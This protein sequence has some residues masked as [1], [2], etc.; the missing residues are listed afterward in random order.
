MTPRR[1]A[2]A[3]WSLVGLLFTGGLVFALILPLT[4]AGCSGAGEEQGG[5]LHEDEDEDEPPGP[6]LFRDVTQAAGVQWSCRNGEEF[7]HTAI[8]EQLGGGVGL[9]DFDGDGLLDLFVVGGG[10]FEKY[11]KDLAPRPEVTTPKPPDELATL[12]KPDR[13][14]KILGHP[15]KLYRNKGNGTF[16][17]VTDKV[18]R[19]DGPWF[20]SHGC[21]VA[22]YDCDGWPDLLL[23][24]WDRVALFHNEPADPRDPAKGRR[25][26]D[27]TRKVG[28]DKVHTWGTSAGFADLD[29]DGFPELYLCCYVDWSWAN[30]PNCVYATQTP[31]ICGP[32]AFRGLR[33]RLFY[34]N[35]GHS[36]TDVSETV[37]VDKGPGKPRQG[38][39]EGGA[40]SSKGLGVVLV[41]LNQDGKSDIYVA[42]DMTAKFL[43]FNVSTP[44]KLK[45]VE[46]ALESGTACNEQGAVDGS[47]GVDAASYDGSGLPHLF[48]TNFE[49]QRHALYHNDWRPG[50]PLEKHF[51]SYRSTSSG[52]AAIGQNFVSWGTGFVDVENGGWEDLII[53][54]GHVLRHPDRVQRGSRKQRAV[55]LRNLGNGRFRDMSKRGGAYF[56]GI[57]L[58]RGLA[59]GDL[60]NDGRVDAVISHVNDPVVIL[61]NVAA[62]DN[63]WLGVELVG[64]K[65]RDVVGARLS[66]EAGGR[67]QWRFAKGGG[68]YLSAR[69]PRHVFGLSKENK[70]GRLTVTW[71][72]GNKQHWDHLAPDRYYR[73]TQ[74]KAEADTQRGER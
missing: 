36:F 66:L 70:V 62:P 67:T 46:R 69:D 65:Y 19:L 11:D 16:E 68:S 41:D 53:V 57:H 37:E 28:L 5:R 18:L 13:R 38:L 7:G 49:R 59:L 48:V 33:H 54:S 51:F 35:A 14:C 43:Y 25:L 9:I 47:M 52:V 8:L 63:H 73:L 40:H 2:L 50:T 31:D 26:V 10:Y 17:E 44:G 71:P 34:N 45:F 21:T 3:A 6:A 12:S 56:D 64:A 29:G 23:T 27:V 74:G 55:L 42:N 24:G 72:N 39:H 60:D 20:Y 4:G 1:L 32:E 30:H 61:K 15:C 58:A 22:D